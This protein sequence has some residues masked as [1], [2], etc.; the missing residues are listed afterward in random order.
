MEGFG[1]TWV[2]NKSRETFALTYPIKYHE[3]WMAKVIFSISLLNF[4]PMISFKP[5]S[6]KEENW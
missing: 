6:A 4:F 2:I 3:E 5:S 1:T